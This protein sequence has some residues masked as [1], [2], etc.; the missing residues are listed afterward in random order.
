[1]SEKSK[2]KGRR[3]K[4]KKELELE[5]KKLKRDLEEQ[6]DRILRL[7]AEFDNYRKYVEKEKERFREIANESLIK[8]LLDVIDSFEL[9]IKDVASR[10]KEIATGIEMIYRK[11]MDVLEKHGLK[12][13]DAVGKKF[14][15]YYHEVFMQEESDE[16]DGTIIE[17]FQ[18]GYMLNFK[19]IR[20]SKVKVSKQKNKG[21]GDQR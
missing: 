14:D 17:E 4:S 1:M 16:P 9:A 8:D 21:N 6:N 11:F 10:D 15:P 18:P 2:K 7:Q 5:I 20:H 12:R 19:V 3:G 13:I